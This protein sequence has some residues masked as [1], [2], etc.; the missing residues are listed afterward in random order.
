MR[1][2]FLPWSVPIG[3]DVELSLVQL[4]GRGQRMGEDLPTD[5]EETALAIAAEIYAEATEDFVFFGHS[6]GA[7][8][9]L[10][11]VRV[12]TLRQIQVPRLIVVSGSNWPGRHV[13]EP[14]HELRDT[15][16]IDRLREM[17]GTPREVLENTELMQLV[18]PILRADF[19]MLYRYRYRA[20]A[21]VKSAL[22]VFAGRNDRHVNTAHLADWMQETQAP[23]NLHLFDGGHFFVHGQ[24][25]AILNKLRELMAL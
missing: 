5:L 25:T 22:H 9:A 1:R 12:A 21:A 3:T 8:L 7:V 18:L 13:H 6:M 19:A 20:E 17:G 4:P 15:Q 24:E 10:E 14:L 23:G 11:V 16:L 2:L